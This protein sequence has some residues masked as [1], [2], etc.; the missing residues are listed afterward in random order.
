MFCSV[1]FGLCEIFRVLV[2]VFHALD[3]GA[4]DGYDRGFGE[5]ALF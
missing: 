3:E 2:G 4:I 1:I 5:Y